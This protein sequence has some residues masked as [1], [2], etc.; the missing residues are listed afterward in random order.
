MVRFRIITDVFSKKQRK[1][2]QLLKLMKSEK[3]RCMDHLVVKDWEG[4]N[5]W[6]EKSKKTIKAIRRIM[7]L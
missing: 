6:L 4:V 1:I 3:D 2:N 5:Y 7:E